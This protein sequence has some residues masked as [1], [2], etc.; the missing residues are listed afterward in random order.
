[1]TP[2]EA[3]KVIGCSPEQVRHLIR[4][5]KI[6]AGRHKIPGGFVYDISSREA[7]RYRD[8]EQICGWPRGQS[9]EWE[10]ED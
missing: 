4:H 10:K 6:K 1:M 2:K 5:S 3:A 7:R 9:Y 8:K